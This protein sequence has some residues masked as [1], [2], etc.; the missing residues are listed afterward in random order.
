MLGPHE[1]VGLIEVF[2]PRV[3]PNRR[4][5]AARRPCKIAATVVATLALLLTLSSCGPST[6]GA[7]SAGT[8]A[9]VTP[10]ACGLPAEGEQVVVLVSGTMHEPRPSLT[11]RALSALRA[12]AESSDA[13]NG[14]GG[15]GS[16]AVVAS[17]DG[18]IRQVLPLTPR[19]ENCDVEHGLQRKRLIEGNLDRVAAVVQK[20]AAAKPGLDLLAALDG[21]VRGLRPG[22]LIVVS[23]A[24]STEG[25]FDLRQVGWGLERDALLGQLNDRG[26]LKDMLTGWQVLLTGVGET[27]GEQLPLTKSARDKLVRY[28][29]AIVTAAGA[30]TCDVDESPLEPVAPLTTVATPLIDVPGIHSAVGPD[31]RVTATLSDTALGFAGDSSALSVDAET[32]LRA[33]G[34]RIAGQLREGSDR[35]VVIRGYVADPPSSTPNGR[36]RLSEQRA[37]VVAQFLMA[38]L[39]ADLGHAPRLDA[40]GVGAPPHMSAIVHGSFDEDIASQM[41]VVTVTY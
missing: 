19:R 16:V 15:K 12:A 22:L 4:A 30:T 6:I 24:L 18:E 21:G 31:G 32:T 5:P 38:E 39:T 10:P 37:S 33:V 1:L 28:V 14:R 11:A 3:Q 13:S 20:V 9:S 29:C 2:W 34:A 23:N 36:R 17:A 8:P 27:A 7:A 41:R 26:L 40:A 35:T 25:G